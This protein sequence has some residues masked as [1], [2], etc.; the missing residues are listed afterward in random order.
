M[1]P[2]TDQSSNTLRFEFFTNVGF[3]D[4]KNTWGTQLQNKNE[5]QSNNPASRGSASGISMTQ[6]S[7]DIEQFGKRVTGMF[8]LT[9]SGQYGFE[10]IRVKHGNSC[11]KLLGICSSTLRFSAAGGQIDLTEQIFM[12]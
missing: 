12:T 2:M 6:S 7:P 3:S 5:Y 8:C 10:L 1:I 11:F 9:I 4:E